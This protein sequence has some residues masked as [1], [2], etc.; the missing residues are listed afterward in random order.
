MAELLLPL[1]PRVQSLVGLRIFRSLYV[2]L[3]YSRPRPSPQKKSLEEFV[4]DFCIPAEKKFE[5]ALGEGTSKRFSFPAPARAILED[6][7]SEAKRRGLWNLWLPKEFPAGAGLT[8][9]EYA[10]LAEV[11]GRSMLSQEACNC[12]APDTGNMEV[13][14]RYGSEAQKD[15]WLTRLLNGTCRSA[16]LMTEPDVV[17][18]HHARTT[19]VN[20]NLTTI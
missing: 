11:T 1:S 6:L 19:Y 2:V 8:N 7:K 4:E 12:S 3:S 5:E 15:K 9:A 10:V 18:V 13:L 17:S 14:L 16:F 20:D